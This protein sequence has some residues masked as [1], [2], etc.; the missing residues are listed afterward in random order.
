MLRQ[1]KLTKLL[2]LIPTVL[3]VTSC[4]RAP[5]KEVVVIHKYHLVPCQPPS[6]KEP[7]WMTVEPTDTPAVRL[8]K[9]YTNY[10]MCRKALDLCI[11]A[12]KVC[13]NLNLSNSTREVKKDGNP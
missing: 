7:K 3:L 13:H 12:N 10:L 4:A 9:L 2:L 11:E 6:V 5:Q 1:R 8:Q